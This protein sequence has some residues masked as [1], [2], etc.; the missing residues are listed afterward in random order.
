[1]KIMQKMLLSLSLAMVSQFSVAD[2][3]SPLNQNDVKQLVVAVS[4]NW[5]ATTATLY[6]FEKQQGKW[7]KKDLTSEVNL[8]RTGLAWGLGLHPKQQGQY[9]KEGDG[10]APAG[11]FELGTA[12]GYLQH[13]N[14]HMP[15]QQMQ[16]GNYCMDVKGS[17][18]YNQ[19]VDEAS[20]GADAVK[21]SSEP[22]RLDIHKN[23]PIYKKGLVVMHNAENINGQGS[24]IFMHLWKGQGVPTAG[25]T[26]MP[27][28]VMD[29][30]L[31]WLDKSQH[32]LYVALPQKQ[33]QAKKQAW[34][35]PDVN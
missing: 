18:Y 29:R 12:F 15:Y 34:S 8:G 31:A 24:C 32:P 1:M 27:E 26:S 5:D 16:A 21:A 9:K 19:I 22:M 25:C 7:I 6:A 28:T 23:L 2:F 33:Y 35:L 13:V 20:V 11:I 14:T 4:N 10:K 17:P 30:L 3:S